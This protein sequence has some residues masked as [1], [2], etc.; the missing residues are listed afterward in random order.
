MNFSEPDLTEQEEIGQVLKDIE[1]GCCVGEFSETGHVTRE[2]QT[3]FDRNG[4]PCSDIR[5]DMLDRLIEDG[6]VTFDEEP[7]PTIEG[8]RRRIYKAFK[9]T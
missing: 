4:F 9:G 6:R 2:E 3:L 8:E 5:T 1:H 7:H